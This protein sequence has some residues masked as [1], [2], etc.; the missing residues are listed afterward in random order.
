MPLEIAL[1]LEIF[2]H[3]TSHPLVQEYANGV[4]SLVSE[5]VAA[6]L[7][8]VLIWPMVIAGSAVDASQRPRVT[9]VLSNFRCV[10]SGA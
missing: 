6:G 9:N 7:G 3:P 5:A 8:V 2:G 10:H 4:I 1:L